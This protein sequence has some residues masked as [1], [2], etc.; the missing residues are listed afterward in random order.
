M[1]GKFP[2]KRSGNNYLQLHFHDL[3]QKESVEST[4]STT[5]STSGTYFLVEAG[6]KRWELFQANAVVWIASGCIRVL[7]HYLSFCIVIIYECLMV[8]Y[9]IMGI[10]YG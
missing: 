2:T 1:R 10:I 7:Y 9:D 6:Q 3:P 4:E 8:R 5:L